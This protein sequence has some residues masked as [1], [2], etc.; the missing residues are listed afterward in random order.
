MNMDKLY[1]INKI[2][3]E[4]LE[5]EEQKQSLV[6]MFDI[7]KI[8]DK[9]SATYRMMKE[10]RDKEFVKFDDKIDELMIEHEKLE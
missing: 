6:D 5:L 8:E 3:K 9:N 10:I 7:E 4:I 2:E 1:K